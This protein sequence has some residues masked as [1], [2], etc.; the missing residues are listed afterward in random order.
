MS[1]ESK[2]TSSSTKG[3]KWWLEQ[4]GVPCMEYGSLPEEGIYTLSK[5]QHDPQGLYLV[6]L[7][8]FSL[9]LATILDRIGSGEVILSFVMLW[10][11]LVVQS[12]AW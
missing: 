2:H 9:V 12:S 3:P 11:Q 7:N 8:D 6:A 5:G 4:A 10:Y 1:H